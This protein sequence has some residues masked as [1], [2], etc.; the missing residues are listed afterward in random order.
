[1]WDIIANAALLWGKHRTKIRA[2]FTAANFFERKR[3]YERTNEYSLNFFFDEARKKHVAKI[4][5][6]EKERKKK[7]EGRKE[8]KK[9]KI[10]NCISFL[11]GLIH[12]TTFE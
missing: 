8:R 9:E 3:R 10:S 6:K 12:A 5:R 7:K 1:M 2:I 11:S 4:R